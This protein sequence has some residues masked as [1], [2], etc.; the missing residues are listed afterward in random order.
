[1]CANLGPLPAEMSTFRGHARIH[2]R[3]KARKVAAGGAE[4]WGKSEGKGIVAVGRVEPLFRAY[5]S[6]FLRSLCLVVSQRDDD[7]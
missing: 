3:Q 5:A 6:F 4:K 2:A 1:M 7:R